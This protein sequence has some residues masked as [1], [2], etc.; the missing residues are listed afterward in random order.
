[1]WII[2][3]VIILET[4]NRSLFIKRQIKALY[5]LYIYQFTSRKR[6]KRISY[7]V[8]SICYLTHTIDE[9]IPLISDKIILIQ[10]QCGNNLMYKSKKI[11]EKKEIVKDILSKKE[12]NPKSQAKVEK[13][14]GRGKSP[15]RE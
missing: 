12:M 3:E 14:M 13:K 15:S 6:I 7:I 9:N 2:W 11:H 8:Q 4:S 1:M 10:I 5:E